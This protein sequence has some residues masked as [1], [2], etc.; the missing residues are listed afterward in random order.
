MNL[1]WITV[2]L[3]SVLLLLTGAAQSPAFGQGL[4]FDESDPAIVDS[5]QVSI[6]LDMKPVFLTEDDKTGSA[7][8][9][10]REVNTDV[11]IPHVT[12]HVKLMRASELLLDERF[13]SHDGAAHL[14]LEHVDA[15][16]T[17]VTGERES[18]YDAIIS[19]AENPAVVRG[20]LLE[21]GLYHYSVTVLSMAEYENKLQKPLSFDL[22]ASIGKTSDYRVT[23]ATGKERTLY[24]KTYFDQIRDLAYDSSSR[25]VTFTMPL[26]W[27]INFLSNLPFLHE[28]VQIP[29]NFAELT[30]SSYVA[31]INGAALSGKE[32]MID[33]A[34][35][36]NTRTVHFMVA[37]DRLIEVARDQEPGADLAVFTL[38]PRAIPK[39]P[40]DILSE[41]E[42]F[43]LQVTWNPAIIEPGSSV[44][45]IVT[46]RDARTLDTIRNSSA[47]F[48]LL[49]D[50][51]EIFRQHHR[52][53]IGAI[54]QDYTF[55]EG[56]GSLSLLIENINETGDSMPLTLTAVR[57]APEE[58]KPLPVQE[59]PAQPEISVA[60]KHK[61][62]VSL[63]AVKNGSSDEVFGLELKIDDG[64]IRY[65]KARGW[66]RERLDQSTIM[67]NTGER[68]IKPGG[69]LVIILIVDNKSSSFEWTAL[70]EAN[71]LSAGNVM[72]R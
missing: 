58:E 56:E 49:K 32:L 27:D 50:G 4:G 3:V 68:P 61:K 36:E 72:P 43:L 25:T 8:I 54:V 34:S 23:D 62:K 45:F 15:T 2:T 12:Y 63:V 40:I 6:T 17:E 14:R 44:K 64:T 55:A 38:A 66:D 18:L 16:D 70:G 20:A 65:V 57:E 48:V 26:N 47:D 13:H 59:E 31:T 22:Y 28:E 69:S 37:K 19:D 29:N 5:R 10:L 41:K 1:A 42:A 71:T 21:G 52:A 60:I 33:D 30:H 46:I 35:Y 9:R 7:V 39:F 67:I 11:T 53:P 51:K 24:I